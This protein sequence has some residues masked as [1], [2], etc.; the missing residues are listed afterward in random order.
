MGQ[1]L[2][3]LSQSRVIRIL[4]QQGICRRVGSD[5][6]S[7]VLDIQALSL[8]FSKR[9]A[10]MPQQLY[11]TRNSL[12]AKRNTHCAARH[13]QHASRKREKDKRVR[14]SHAILSKPNFRG[15]S[16]FFGFLNRFLELTLLSSVTLSLSLFLRLFW[17][18]SCPGPPIFSQLVSVTVTEPVKSL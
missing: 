7:C 2:Q 18:F 4:R 6:A 13:Q 10:K 11:A 15:F 9:K 16:T 12:H 5:A 1:Q 17:L 3:V 8:F 14:I